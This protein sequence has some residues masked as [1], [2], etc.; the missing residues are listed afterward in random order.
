MRISTLFI[1]T[2]VI[3][4]I[5][6][7]CATQ[8]TQPDKV[9]A[10]DIDKA[11][12]QTSEADIAK[13][14]EILAL[15]N[16]GKLDKA[17]AALKDFAD[18]QQALAGPW[19]NLALISIKR[20]KLEEAEQRLQKALAR[21]PEMPQ[22]LNMMGFIEKQKGNIV[23]ARDYYLRAIEIKDNYALA[24]YN[25][26][27]VYDIYI[28]DIPKAINHYQKYLALTKYKDKKTVQWLDQLK[29]SMKKG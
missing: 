6:T 20:N 3:A 24:H 5:L 7:G 9:S 12:K 21:N 16:E 29:A 26:A 10:Q 27:L 28:Q 18:D 13:Y 15:I 19:A 8:E 14:K 22:A 1:N 17:E 23:K 11:L 2:L 25:L 4:A